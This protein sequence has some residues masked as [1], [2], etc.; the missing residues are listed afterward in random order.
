MYVDDADH[1]YLMTYDDWDGDAGKRVEKVVFI[2]KLPKQL[3][4]NHFC[5]TKFMYV[6]KMDYEDL[7]CVCERV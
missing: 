6:G 4:M 7:L 1:E 2:P 3:D 5:A